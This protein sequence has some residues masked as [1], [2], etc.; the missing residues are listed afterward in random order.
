MRHH[1]ELI[2]P[3]TIMPPTPLAKI[4][5]RVLDVMYPLSGWAREENLYDCLYDWLY[6]GGNFA[7]TKLYLRLDPERRRQFW[8]ELDRESFSTDNRISQGN[9]EDRSSFDLDRFWSENSLLWGIEGIFEDHRSST[10]WGRIWSETDLPKVDALWRKWFP[11]EEV[12]KFPLSS[13]YPEGEQDICRVDRIPEKLTAYAVVVANEDKEL[14]QFRV[15]LWGEPV[16]RST[17]FNGF[18]LDALRQCRAC[19]VEPAPDWL[20]VTLDCRHG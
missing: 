1:V 3:P 20:A 12:G 8:D 4:K 16:R 14:F 15:E 6:F 17:V 5:E 18:V 7:G 10:R 13:Y 9:V 2:V 19:G 11:E